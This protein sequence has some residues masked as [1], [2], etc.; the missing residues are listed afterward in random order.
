MV[1][2]NLKAHNPYD[3]DQNHNPIVIRKNTL[4][5]NRAS[6]TTNTTSYR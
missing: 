4:G 2:I 5:P 6:V 1:L 3:D